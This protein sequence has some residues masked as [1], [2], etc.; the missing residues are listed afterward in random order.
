MNP[1]SFRSVLIVDDSERDLITM[2][3]LLEDAGFTGPFATVESGAL[4][5]ELLLEKGELFQIAFF[6]LRMPLCDGLQLLEW[7]RSRSELA[8]MKIVMIT[9]D[10]DPDLIM[11]ARDLGA[12]GFFSKYP[13]AGKLAAII[14]NIAPGVIGA[15]AEE[16]R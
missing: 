4:A 15:M 9:G 14:S 11:Q 3:R 5:K 12:D 16:R 10:E 7:A 8:Q 1:S 6:D 2:S 13:R